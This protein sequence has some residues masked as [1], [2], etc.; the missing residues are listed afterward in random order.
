MADARS[1]RRLV[2]VDATRGI[3]LLGMMAVH[4]L[5]A[6]DGD[7]SASTAYLLA[8]GRSAATFAVLAGVGLALATGRPAGAAEVAAAASRPPRA[9]A[10]A[11][12]AARALAIGALGLAVGYAD[13]GVA[14]ILAYYAL[15]FVLAIPL[16]GLRPSALVLTAAAVAL[17]VPV[18]GHLL[19]AVLPRAGGA[20]PTFS[21]LVEDPAGLLLELGLTGYYPAL[22]WVAYLATGLAVGR[23]D[24]RSPRVAAGL[25]AGGLGLAVAAP[26]TSAA[27][28][29][30]LGGRRELLAATPGL[31]PG[32]LDAALSTSLYGAP[33]TT[34][35]WWLTVAAPHSSTPLDLAHTTGT[36]LALLGAVL[37]LARIAA[38]A[39]RALA[40]AGS[41]TLTLYCVHVLLLAS[42]VLPRDP[43]ESYAL[44]AGAALLLAVLWRRSFA[45]GPVEAL[46]AV[47]A[48]AAARVALRAPAARAPSPP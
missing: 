1:S 26:L 24:L 31:D 6:T 33:P 47:L 38:P 27:L 22:A 16:L 2:G 7:G 12:V 3:A 4:V 41:M 34:T 20:N 9:A 30:R 45:R 32:E 37:L 23:L 39:L 42:P 25:L 40:A 48:R 46:V 43:E 18:V 10:A 29:D 44:Q 28:L 15:L 5:P 19:R 11:S 21:S 36:A 13:S 14:V 17:V 35:W 8:S